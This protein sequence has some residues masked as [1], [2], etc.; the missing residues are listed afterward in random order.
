MLGACL[1]LLPFPP[2]HEGTLVRSVSG[3]W[4][5]TARTWCDG[6]THTFP[7]K[8]KTVA[9]PL[10]A[11]AAWCWLGYVWGPGSPSGEPPGASASPP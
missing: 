2:P 8:A 6:D 11:L 7:G 3:P 5:Q 9:A 10:P 4:E 1:P